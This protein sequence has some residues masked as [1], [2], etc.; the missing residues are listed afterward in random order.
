MGSTHSNKNNAADL[1]WTGDIDACPS[2]FDYHS[3]TGIYILHSSLVELEHIGFFLIPL[4]VTYRVG[5]LFDPHI[6][7]FTTN[8]IPTAQQREG[9]VIP[10]FLRLAPRAST[11]CNGFSPKSICSA[12]RKS[13]VHG[14]QLQDDM[15]QHVL[16]HS[17]DPELLPANNH[18]LHR[19]F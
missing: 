5:V 1:W 3:G 15:V 16:E 4:T 2:L 12:N 6:I 11:I 10:T 9:T 19:C 14:C 7:P 13:I 8:I 18:G 17:L